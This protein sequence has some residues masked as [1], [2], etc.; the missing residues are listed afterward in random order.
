MRTDWPTTVHLEI[1]KELERQVPD[2]Y[3]GAEIS[4]ASGRDVTGKLSWENYQVKWEYS[5]TEKIDVDRFFIISLKDGHPCGSLDVI[6][7]YSKRDKRAAELY[8]CKIV[9]YILY[10]TNRL[11][12]GQFGGHTSV[13]ADSPQG[14]YRLEERLA[15]FSWQSCLP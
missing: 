3:E 2:N 1:I 11:I 12:N 4:L 14:E 6:E 13:R 7:W 8:A 5:D 10:L 15:G 9:K